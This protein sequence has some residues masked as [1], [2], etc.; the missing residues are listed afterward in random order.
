MN[1]HPDV[2][3]AILAGGRARRLG[4]A[5]KG[6]LEVDGRTTLSRLLD[7]RALTGD[8]FLVADDPRPYASYP[9]RAIADVLKGR[10]APGGLHA[11]LSHSATP[12]VVLVA[13]DM[14]FVSPALVE[15]LLDV[16]APEASWVCAEKDGV[17]E[18]MP[19]VYAA[20][21]A[22]AVGA[23]L[24]QNPSLRGLLGGSPGRI[25]P[26]ERLRGVDPDLRSFASIN[27]PE[28]AER[29]GVALPPARH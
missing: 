13:C 17:L 4:G 10:G 2:T 6:L 5:A 1:A 3:L 15:A 14:P 11:A 9:V 25:V 16:R 22:G 24:P 28:D 8:A 26:A 21:W 29:W 23:A 19:G 20:R 12:W 7:L 27:A 18:P